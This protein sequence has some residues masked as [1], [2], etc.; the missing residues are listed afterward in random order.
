[1]KRDDT[2]RAL[3]AEKATQAGSV[4]FATTDVEGYKHRHV[5]VV[6]R[7]MVAEG[8]LFRGK[9][10]H[11]TMRLFAEKGW[12]EAYE[13]GRRKLATKAPKLDASKEPVYPVDAKGNPLYKITVVPSKFDPFEAQV[14][15][16][17]RWNGD[18]VVR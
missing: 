14:R 3:L 1:M 13:T 11:R 8:S 7:S 17:S 18:S 2:L 10:G 5:D 9:I 16:L 12:A 4:G 15:N 6:V